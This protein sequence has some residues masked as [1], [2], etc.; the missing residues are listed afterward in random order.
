M[1]E[2]IKRVSYK[3]NV[4]RLSDSICK[5]I[6]EGN[7]PVIQIMGSDPCWQMT[8]ALARTRSIMSTKGYDMSWYSYFEKVKGDRDGD[9]IPSVITKI[10]L[11][12]KEY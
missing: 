6:A 5:T 8:K 12:A 7:I 9:E 11:R 10:I 3:T 2:V 1:E 4:V